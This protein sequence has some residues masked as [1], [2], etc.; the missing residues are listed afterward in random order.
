MLKATFMSYSHDAAICT[1]VDC[2]LSVREGEWDFDCGDRTDAPFVT[3]L[4]RLCGPERCTP[5]RGDDLKV[6]MKERRDLLRCDKK[7]FPHAVFS[8]MPLSD[9]F[10]LPRRH[11][12]KLLNGYRIELGVKAM[13]EDQVCNT[14]NKLI[15]NLRAVV[16]EIKT[17]Q[18]D[19]DQHANITAVEYTR[20]LLREAHGG[21]DVSTN[22]EIM[23]RLLARKRSL[24]HK[25]AATF[26]QCAPSRST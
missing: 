21:R 12:E 10:V 25:V 24:F 9:P 14:A 20:T 15:K 7:D 2:P 23:K 11:L 6:R 18:L 16:S 1:L 19:A 8:S 13:Q 22:I 5:Y 26:I 4:M 17:L 3:R